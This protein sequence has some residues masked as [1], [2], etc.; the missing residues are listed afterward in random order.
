MT[1]LILKYHLDYKHLASVF[2]LWLFHITAIVGIS[3][4]YF[5]WFISK[6]PLTL[7][8]LATLLVLNFPLD[9]AKKIVFAL[10][11]FLAGFSLEWVGVHYG[12]LF[13]AY[14]YGNNLGIK[15]DGVPLLIGVNWAVLI[16][17]C[18][19]IASL[20]TN[21]K[22]FKVLLGAFFM[23]FLD[24]FIEVPAPLFDYW[25]F[26]TGTA[27]LQN[28]IAWYLISAVLL[29]LM[30]LFKIKGDSIFSCHLYAAQLVFF[31]FFYGTY[32]L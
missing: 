5:D 28:F 12:F 17:S 6:T 15:V 11:L 31:G 32:S 26:D 1:Q 8:L 30:E 27:P 24:F 29:A 7:I 2:V 25:A 3:I 20:I 10:F 22:V 23:V 14:S 18:G 9:N 21:N 13:G 16:L 4:G 19:A